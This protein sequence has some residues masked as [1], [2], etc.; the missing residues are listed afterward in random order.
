M[1]GESSTIAGLTDEFPVTTTMADA[2]RILRVSAGVGRLW[3][4]EDEARGETDVAVLGYRFWRR[5]LGSRPDVLGLTVTTGER[6]YRVI[7]VLSAASDHP[8]IAMLSSPIWVPRIVPRSQ[9]QGFMSV[10][11]RVRPD[12]TRTMVADELR[13]LAAA[14]EWTPLVTGPLDTERERIGRWMLLALGASGFS[15]SWAAST[16]RI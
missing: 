4:S 12:R 8:E 5:E 14:P 7:G 9:Q 2:F 15:C 3:T 16:P 1:M 11:A 6:S 13:A 10:L